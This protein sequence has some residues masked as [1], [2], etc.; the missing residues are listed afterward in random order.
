MRVD[1]AT[2]AKD[3][4]LCGMQ[5]CGYTCVGEGWR[6]GAR[7]S[8]KSKKKTTDFKTSMIKKGDYYNLL[9]NECNNL[10]FIDEK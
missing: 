7:D 5:Y 3:L 6:T 2:I 8:G 10:L 1:L 9:I 4:R